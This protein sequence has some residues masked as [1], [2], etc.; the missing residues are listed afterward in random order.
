[1]QQLWQTVTVPIGDSATGK[2]NRAYNKLK[3]ESRISNRNP[4]LATPS[5][6]I[7]NQTLK[8]FSDYADEYEPADLALAD[9]IPVEL[10]LLNVPPDQP[11]ATGGQLQTDQTETERVKTAQVEFSLT[12]IANSLSATE[13]L[14]CNDDDELLAFIPLELSDLSKD[15]EKTLP[16]LSAF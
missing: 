7:N 11:R 15:I 8:A 3:K 10:A 16:D 14:D 5:V 4:E 12:E 9:L 13:E 2:Q 6:P 1:M